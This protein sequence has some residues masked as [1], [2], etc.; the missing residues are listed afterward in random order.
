MVVG[1]R[2]WRQKNGAFRDGRGGDEKGESGKA[3]GEPA[4][5]LYFADDADKRQ[6]LRQL[7]RKLDPTM[8]WAENNYYKLRINQQIA[9]LV[10][11]SAFWHDYARHNGTS[12]FLSRN[13]AEA[14]RN[15]TEMMFAL[16]VLDLPFEAGKHDVTFAD[17]RMTMKPASQMI[18]FHEE[19]RP[20]EGPASS[21]PILVSQNFY[22]NGDRFREENGEKYDKFVTDEFIIHTVYGCQVV[23]TNPTSARQK[24]NVLLQL[25]LGAIPV[26]NGQFTRSVP[27][28]LEPYRTA[29]I[30]YAFYFPKAGKYPQFPAHVARNEQ[31]V[32]AAS[33]ATFNVVEKPTKTDVTSW[34]YVS[35]HGTDG[36]VL[37]FLARENVRALNLEKIAFRMKDRGFFE[38]V[39]RLLDERH[40]YHPTLW[41]YGI[42]HADLP[43]IRQF[44]LHQDGLVGQCGGPINS[45]LLT[46]DPVARHQYEH[47]EYKPLVN[48]RAHSLGQRRQIVND[49]LSAQYHQLLTTLTYSNALNDSDVLAV[50][51]YLLLQDRIEEAVEAFARVHPEK[52]A[53]RMQ[54]DYCAAYL[55]LFKDEPM[56][57]RAIATAY[58]F[59]PVDRWRNAFAAVVAQIDEIEGKGRKLVPGEEHNQNQGGLAATEP[60]FEVAV[61]AQG[62]NLTFQN[63]DVVRVNYYL[64]DVELLFSTSPFV[65]RASGQFATIKP[66]GTEFVKLPPARNKHVFPLPAEFEGKNVLVEVTAAGKTR[67]VPHFA[68]T[69]TVNLSENYGQLQVTETAGGKAVGK[70]YVK[71]YAKLADGSV[72][73]HKDGYTDLRGRFDY[74]SVNTPERQAIERFAILV[75]SDDRGAT[76]RDVAPP[77]R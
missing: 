75:L 74:S 47:L 21:T 23:V 46:I 14:S 42:V 67:A 36:E 32:I 35:Q 26:L 41:S 51:Y 72:K 56:K 73:F 43:A 53:T 55:E 31:F 52:L 45:P 20:A 37:A 40:T 2:A 3:R 63:V 68:T 34:D 61:T 33:M 39:I 60:G 30:D 15:F 13:L 17:G 77:Q 38:A 29:T 66:N 10:P 24:L 71:V 18:V 8:E 62:V 65:Q 22:R 11:I 57:A 19:V 27:L 58:A 50:V 54:Y 64:M 28:D 4:A 59:H 5:E 48:A 12:A 70:V 44:L 25:P 49:A 7:Y 6:A 76:I 16:A 9:D 69:M 1:P